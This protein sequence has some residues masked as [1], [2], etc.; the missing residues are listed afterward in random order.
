MRSAVCSR[1][2][3]SSTSPACRLRWAV[4]T[5]DPSAGSSTP[6][7]SQKRQPSG[8]G[9]CGSAKES[10]SWARRP[11]H[12]SPIPSSCAVH[13]TARSPERSL[14]GAGSRGSPTSQVN[15]S[16]GTGPAESSTGA[17]DASDDSCGLGHGEGAARLSRVRARNTSRPRSLGIPPPSAAR[18]IT[19]V[20]TL[21]ATGRPGRHPRAG[22]GDQRHPGQGV[23]V[24]ARCVGRTPR[25]PAATLAAG[26]PRRTA[27]SLS[28][29]RPAHPSSASAGDRR[30][31]PGRA[32][33]R[34]RPTHRQAADARSR[35]QAR[36]GSGCPSRQLNH[37]ASASA[38]VLIPAGTVASRAGLLGGRPGA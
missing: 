14:A 23:R 32:G 19:R 24:G 1:D 3:Q 38:N 36:Y 7:R 20:P 21:V 5:G 13:S 17:P 15:R 18:A 9:R 2:R 27:P 29:T 22:S 8:T 4:S 35:S 31:A 10:R 37:R 12:A 34:H 28:C 26:R 33:P 16:P 30:P 6:A 11:A 25:E